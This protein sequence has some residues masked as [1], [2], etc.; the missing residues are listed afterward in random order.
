MKDTTLGNAYRVISVKVQYCCYWAETLYY[1]D[2]SGNVVVA[3]SS[4]LDIYIYSGSTYP[5][6]GIT[7]FAFLKTRVF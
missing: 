1:I 3:W 5:K 2:L 4:P 6:G 7:V